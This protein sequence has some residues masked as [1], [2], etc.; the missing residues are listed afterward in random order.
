[1]K[2][3]EVDLKERVS[4]LSLNIVMTAMIFGIFL[5]TLLVTAV[6]VVLFVHFGVIDVEIKEMLP[7]YKRIVLFMS[8]SSVVLGTSLA[9]FISRFPM[10]PVKTLVDHL[11]VLAAGNYKSRICY[12][13]PFSELSPVKA[14]VDSCNTLAEELENTEILR[15]DFINNFSHE[16]KTP[17]SSIAGFANLAQNGDLTEEERNEYLAVI[18]REARRLAQLAT[19]ILDLTRVEN[20]TILTEKTSFNLSEQIRSCFV[21]L[22]DKWSQKDQDFRLEFDEHYITANE[23]LLKHIW[24]NLLDNAIKF[25]P[26]DGTIAVT[27]QERDGQIAVCVSNTGSEI[28]EDAKKRIFHK[29]YQAD[30]SH[31][32]AGNGIGLSIV[33]R[34]VE[35]HN[36]EINVESGDGLTSFTVV[37][38]K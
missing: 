19:N 22:E 18:E 10:R 38:P 33:K 23:P 21:L 20:Q 34:V 1:M 36:G 16:F 29:F 7:V 5:I 17:I 35:L 12:K 27:I 8:L 37:L 11:R 15:S 30:E 14:I 9:G 31:A 26:Y 3:K 28:P 4:T 25:A 6:M 24:M 2:R 32:S 13:K